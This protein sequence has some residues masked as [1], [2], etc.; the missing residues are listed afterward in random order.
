MST[1]KYTSLLYVWRLK[2]SE[3]K[4]RSKWEKAQEMET[5]SRR[6]T[7]CNAVIIITIIM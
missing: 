4:R 1:T 7:L 5:K 3:M 6:E 2:E